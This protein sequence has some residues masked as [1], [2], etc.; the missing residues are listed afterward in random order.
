MSKENGRYPGS[1]EWGL[2]MPNGSFKPVS[3]MVRQRILDDNEVPLFQEPPGIPRD[4]GYWSQR[5]IERQQQYQETAEVPRDHV[6]ITLPGTCVINLIGDQHVGNPTTNYERIAQE[7]ELILNTPRSYVM[8]LGDTVDGFFFNPA[9]FEQI[10]QAPEQ[11]AYVRSMIARLAAAKRLL[12]GWGGDHDNWA[13]KMGVS[14]Y[15]YFAQETGAH[16]MYGVGYVTMN[17]GEQ[18]YKLSGA[19][20]HGGFSMYNNTHAAMRMYRDNAEGADVCVTAHTHKKGYHRQAVRGF[21]GEAHKVD[22][23]SLGPYKATDDYSRKRGFGTQ[24][25]SEMFGAAIML[26]ADRHQVVYYD[27]ILDANRRIVEVV[28]K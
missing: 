17:V 10:E 9:Q 5:F 28:A 19:H 20:R 25:T 12:V 16:Y 26:M 24:Q 2:F 8:L 3:E 1:S 22:F 18:T 11:F 7:I 13:K 27:D 6:T 23:I 4:F 15:A 21:G 14:A